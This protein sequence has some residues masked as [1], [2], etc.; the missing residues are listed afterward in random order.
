MNQ[1]CGVSS[2][3]VAMTSGACEVGENVPPRMPSVIATAEFA[4]PAASAVFAN[5]V[6]SVAIPIAAMTPATMT[7][8]TPIGG[9]QSAPMSSVVATTSSVIAVTPS[10]NDPNV[11]P[12]RI[13]CGRM[14]PA[15]IRASVPCRRSSNRLTMPIWAEKNR[16]RIAIEALK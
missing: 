11:L 7:A 9:P 5:D 13:V 10:T 15:S 1:P 3:R 2:A 8:A 12:N 6:T 4:A 14:G 16:N